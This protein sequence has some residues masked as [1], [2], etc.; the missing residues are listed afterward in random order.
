MIFTR[1]LPPGT[2]AGPTRSGVWIRVRSG[3]YVAT[4]EA[5][6]AAPGRD[7]GG[8]RTL[9][10]ARVLA[11]HEQL[12]TAHVVSHASAALV[13]GLP[14]LT[15]PSTTHV[16]QTVKPASDGAEDVVRHTHRL[17]EEHR[18]VR[19]GIR[20]TT[21]E[22]TLV[23]CATL[24]PPLGGL[25]VVDAGLHIGADRARCAEILTAAGSRRG[26]RRARAVFDLA[27]DGAESPGES[28]LRFVFLR[29]GLPAP[30]TQ[31]RVPTRLGEYWGDM[32]WPDWKV[33][34]EYDGRAKYGGRGG[35]PLVAEKRRQDAIEEEGWR[36]LRV[37]AEDLRN[38]ADVVRRVARVAPAGTCAR[39][40]PARMLG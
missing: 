37:V 15:I 40:R 8:T 18:T 27:D 29:A 26:V 22:R 2:P 21:L 30:K 20:V 25:V 19:H 13:W 3:A 32:G 14:L 34:A 31:I 4:P 35:E 11:V 39:L 23:D 28:W 10:L 5:D 12:R 9:A 17:P 38:P 16:I 24:L 36:V 6:P 1:D 7:P 33:L